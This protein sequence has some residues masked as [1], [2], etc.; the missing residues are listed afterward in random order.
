MTR[1]PIGHYRQD[2]DGRAGHVVEH[3][4]FVYPQSILWTEQSSQSLDAA[5]ARL[6]GLVPQMCFERGPNGRPN[7]C[8]QPLEV[9]DSFGSKDDLERH[10]GQ[11]IARFALVPNER[12][13][14]PQANFSVRTARQRMLLRAPLGNG[15][16]F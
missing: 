15:A 14:L 13:A 7:T 9:F 1:P 4:N 12:L 2:L 5:A 16:P 6:F 11:T 3:P 10:S 8:R